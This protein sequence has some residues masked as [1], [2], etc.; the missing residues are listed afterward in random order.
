MKK[1]IMF[2]ALLLA[3]IN[4]L[5]LVIVKVGISHHL[6]YSEHIMN[7]NKSSIAK[8]KIEKITNKKYKML[9]GS[10]NDGIVIHSS[11]RNKPLK[12]EVFRKGTVRNLIDQEYLYISKE[13][14]FPV[15]RYNWNMTADVV[16]T[17]SFEDPK[18]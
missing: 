18:C 10:Y 16:C 15:E 12:I 2:I 5:A 1:S 17:D 8:V 7:N 4:L 9:N 13:T 6:S 11:Y 3:I 14:R